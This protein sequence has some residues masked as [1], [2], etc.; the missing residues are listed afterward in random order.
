MVRWFV[1]GVVL[2]LL[3]VFVFTGSRT[4]SA[5]APDA[6]E[7]I[8]KKLHKGAKAVH[9]GIEKDL[10]EKDVPWDEVQM[11]SKEYVTLT[12]D[13][14]KETPEKGGADSW[15]KL[16]KAYNAAAKSLET[17]ASKKDGK[18]AT[19]AFATLSESCKACHKEHR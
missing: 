18:L 14:T 13:L 6:I 4:V 12:T 3:S 1:T 7:K 2:S 8:M 11:L 19:D 17:A 5:Q 9:K 10:D 16:T 15:K